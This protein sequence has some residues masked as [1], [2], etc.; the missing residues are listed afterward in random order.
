M[1]ELKFDREPSGNAE[2]IVKARAQL[3]SMY[4]GVGWTVLQIGALVALA[5]YLLEVG[6]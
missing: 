6:M 2:R 4:W 5:W 3:T 1:A